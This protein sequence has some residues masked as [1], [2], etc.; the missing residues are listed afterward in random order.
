[1][2]TDPM[3]LGNNYRFFQVINDTLDRTYYLFNDN[4]NNGKE[5]QRP[6]NSSEDSLK[7]KLND[8]VSV[9][10]QCISNPTYLYYNSLRQISGAG[11]GGGTTP[12]NPPSN[13]VGGALGIFSAHTVQRKQIQIK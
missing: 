7:V 10:M 11:P 9:E 13:I 6:L 3:T 5:N 1:M 2:Y 4:L 12:A 8:F